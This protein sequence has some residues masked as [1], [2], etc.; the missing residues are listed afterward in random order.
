MKVVHDP[1]ALAAECRGWQIA[2][3]SVGIVPTMGA[4]HAGHRA[5]MEEARTTSDRVVVSIFVNPT[6]F[7]DSFDFENYPS[8]IDL[9]L[10]MCERTDV[11]L[12]Y[13]PDASIMYPHGFST[14]IHVDRLTEEWEGADRPGHFDGVATVVTK[15]LAA[16]R[17][18]R[19]FFGQKDFQQCAVIRRL[20]A[21]LDLPVD[22]VVCPTVRDG[23][24]LALSSRN[25]RLDAS[26]R[27]RALAIP[28]SLLEV[29]RRY[30]SGET[31]TEALCRSGKALLQESDLTVHYFEVVDSNDLVPISQART[32][33]AV[34]VA[35]SCDGVRLLDNHVLT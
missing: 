27:E 9:D 1:Q 4:L 25:R 16:S 30:E 21:D 33:A 22:I 35:A 7:S 17:A 20:V 31:S 19:A 14:T 23:D 34:I 5:L 12:V 28:R 15:L 6:Q 26:A 32:G 10:E 29:Q 24:G 2:G 11:D 13:V 8:S 3:D 18:D